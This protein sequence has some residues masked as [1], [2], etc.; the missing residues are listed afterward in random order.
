MR[1]LFSG[2][3]LCS[4]AAAI[5][6]ERL[7]TVH[8]NAPA[9]R[10]RRLE[11]PPSGHAVL[12]LGEEEFTRGRPHPM[13][14]PAAR[15][16]RLAEE[17]ADPDVGV[18]L[19]DVVLGY[20]SHPDPASVLVPPIREALAARPQLAVVGYVLGTEAD[21]QVR[22]RQAAA[23]EDAG[24]R[25]AGTNAAAARLS[26]VTSNAPAGRARR[27]QGEP[28]GHVCLDLGEEEFTRGRPHPMID[29]EARAERLRAEAADPRV[30]VLL[31]DVVLGYSSHPDPAGAVAPVIR[32]ALAERPQLAVVAYVLGT[33]ADPQVRSRQEAT[34]ADA[35]ARLAPSNAAAARLAAALAG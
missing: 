15:A 29:P 35:G 27:L 4:E 16:E 11:G 20:A 18:I 6:A 8:T 17:A 33:E 10:A 12:D 22:S 5:L 13:I 30:G 1:G 14:D 7:G 19:L 34:L 25:L 26:R 24:V 32:E 3:T 31:L 9:G 23:L 2:G 21:P 28:E